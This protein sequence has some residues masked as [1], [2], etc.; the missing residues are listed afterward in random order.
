MNE[1]I[2]Q[3]DSGKA[4]YVLIR[5]TTGQVYSTATT[6]FVTYSAGDIANYAVS[7]TEHG[8]GYYLGDFPTTI[9]AAGVYPIVAYIRSG[10]SPATSDKQFAIGSIDWTGTNAN[11]TSF[12]FNLTSLSYVKQYLNI[13][14]STYDN[15]LTA[16]LASASQSIQTYCQRDFV[17]QDYTE[18]SS[19][20]RSSAS[21]LLLQT[22]VN[23][24]TQVTLWPWTSSPEVI[25]GNQFIVTSWGEITL[26]PTSN[27]TGYFPYGLQ[28]VLTQY[29]AGYISIPPDVQEATAMLVANA[30]NA[31]GKNTTMLIEQWGTSYKYQRRAI[32]DMYFT[33]EIQNKLAKY[34]RVV[35]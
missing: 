21:L 26:K 8:D 30:Y 3:T 6:T 5:N 2:A 34:R 35:L 23:S 16:L 1:I 32:S 7:L 29:N 15:L 11:S 24:I 22:P 13:T 28:T 18:Y 10:G 19:P 27:S 12:G 14:V 20:P 33:P 25:A 31:V 17:Q 9:S 4:V